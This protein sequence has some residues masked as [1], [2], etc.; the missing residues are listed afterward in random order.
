MEAI[1]HALY[2]FFIYAILGWVVEVVYHVINVGK[3][4]NRGFLKGPYCPIYGFGMFFIL[5]LLTP[6]INHVGLLFLLSIL[7]TTLIELIAGF[8]LEHFL[9][10][11]WWDY[12]SLPFNF[13]GYICVKFS[14]YWGFGA[15]IVV[16]FIHPLIDQL[17]RFLPNY[18]IYLFVIIMLGMMLVDFITTLNNVLGLNRQLKELDEMSEKIKRFSDDM[19][20]R[21]T[22]GVIRSQENRK[23]IDE[24]FE[25]ELE[26]LSQKHKRM[27]QAFPNLRA[28]KYDNILRRIKEKAAEK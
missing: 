20:E 12:S 10:K 28:K 27:L 8:L 7:I 6:Y 18:L 11:R 17:Y 4:V 24:R 9:Q 15:L 14:L 25:A 22:E 3:F 19:G 1:I 26:R 5:Y 2:L 21:I 13:K 23:E 16:K